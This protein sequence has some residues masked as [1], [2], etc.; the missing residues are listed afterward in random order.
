MDL[1][2]CTRI[3]GLALRN[4]TGQSFV[5][6]LYHFSKPEIEHSECPVDEYDTRTR[7]SGTIHLSH[8]NTHSYSH[9]SH[10]G[11]YAHPSHF[12]P[13]GDP[14]PGYDF[15]TFHLPGNL[16]RSPGRYAISDC[17]ALWDLLRGDRPCQSACESEA[18]LSRTT[19]VYSMRA[20]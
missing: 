9:S 17:L 12:G 11:R 16:C 13:Y 10:A 6:A 3:S 4:H 15:P 14:Y 8:P 18:H 7:L 5:V 20:A 19:I 2:H 1:L